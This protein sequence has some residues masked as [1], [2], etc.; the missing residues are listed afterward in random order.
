MFNKLCAYLLML[1][2]FVSSAD[3]GMPCESIADKLKNKLSYYSEKQTPE[4]LKC[5]SV[6]RVC[7]VADRHV[8]SAADIKSIKTPYEATTLVIVQS[9]PYEENPLCLVGI[10]SGG[11]A[12]AW[13]FEAYIVVDGSAVS[14]PGMGDAYAQGD[15]VAPKNAAILTYRMFEKYAEKP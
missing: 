1:F 13:V 12:A 15:A 10:Y 5:I 4:F 8:V 7:A 9:L 6:Y 3:P 11:S 2:P 14:Y